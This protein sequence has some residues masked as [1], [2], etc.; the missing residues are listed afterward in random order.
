MT[1]LSANTQAI[2]M[3][4]SPLIAGGST[5]R[6]LLLT[7]R[8]YTNLVKTLQQIDSQPADLIDR[9][10]VSDILKTLEKHQFDQERLS[11]LLGR[12]MQLGL[13]LEH[14]QQRSIQVISRADDMYPQRLK[15]TLQYLAPALLY[16]CG[17]IALLQKGGL[18]VVG[19]R[20]VDIDLLEY[21][22]NVGEIAASA[23]CTIVSGGA[24]GIDQAAMQGATAAGGRVIGVM[25]NNLETAVMRNRSDLLQGRLLLCSPF[26]PAVRFEVW[27]AMDRNKLIYALSDIALVVESDVEKGGTW[28]GAVEQIQKL[29][30][31]PVYT[32][33]SGPDSRGL[34]VLRR[35]GAHSWPEFDDREDL[36]RF[37]HDIRKRDK[38]PDLPLFSQQTTP[39]IDSSGIV[40]DSAYTEASIKSPEQPNTLT[41]G[42]S[43]TSPES[44]GPPTP[45][46]VSQEESRQAPRQEQSWGDQ[47][48][49]HVEEIILQLLDELGPLKLEEIATYLKTTKG[50][51]GQT[52]QWLKRMLDAGKIEKL[53]KSRYQGTE[54]NQMSFSRPL[55]ES[56]TSSIAP[57]TKQ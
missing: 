10:K 57:V 1:N 25:A 37:I 18:A 20:H 40:V 52:A 5:E 48:F 16:V 55:N 17:D 31:V 46:P 23:D 12:G 43:A 22:R 3:L 32:R 53:P 44:Y 24:K 19:S 41:I 26:D 29:K 2:L 36:R 28:Q 4:V 7:H 42:E 34:A 30:V 27:R 15:K 14:W 47:L 6:K 56:D 54:S 51:R 39:A 45:L 33:T 38:N 50:H 13:A 9:E 21:T 11:R 8:E 35:L 49:A